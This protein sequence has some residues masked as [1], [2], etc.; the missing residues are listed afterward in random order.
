MKPY[1]LPK[2]LINDKLKS[3]TSN[4]NKEAVQMKPRRVFKEPL[5][6]NLKPLTLFFKRRNTMKTKIFFASLLIG[7][8]FLTSLSYPADE[9]RNV[10]WQGRF[11]DPGTQLVL[12]GNYNITYSIYQAASGGTALWSETQNTF[13]DSGIANVFLGSV[14]PIPD[15]V[16]NG[17]MMY[18]GVRVGSDPEM[19]PRSEIVCTPYARYAFAGGGW[20]DSGNVVTLATGTDK[21]GIGT[22]NPI[23]KLHVEGDAYISGVLRVGSPVFSG[24]TN[25]GFEAIGVF[26]KSCP[27]NVEPSASLEIVKDPV[28]NPDFLMF[29][30]TETADGDMLIVRN[31]GNVGIGTKTPQEKL[32]VNGGVKIGTTTNTNAGTIRWYNG[33]FQGY[34]GTVWVN[35]DE[36][37][38]TDNDWCGIGS[39]SL[40]PCT[41]TDKVGIGT[42]SPADMLHVKKDQGG[43]ITYAIVD[44]GSGGSNT[45]AGIRFRN[46]NGDAGAIY[47]LS[48]YNGNALVIEN[49]QVNSPIK[50]IA[51]GEMLTLQPT[52][53]PR[54]AIFE[55]DATV[56]IGTT[57]V[58]RL[59][60]EGAVAVGASY[61]GTNTAPTNGMIVQGNV[62]I[63]TTN[64]QSTLHVI[65]SV[66]G[67]TTGAVHINN[68]Y[69]DA[70]ALG[71]FASA[72][73]TGIRGYATNPDGGGILGYNAQMT[74]GTGIGSGVGGWANSLQGK[75]VF[76]N[77]FN[78]DG[79]AFYAWDGKNYFKGKVGIGTEFPNTKVDIDGDIA[80]RAGS[81]IATNGVTNHNIAIGARSFVRITGPNAPFTITGIAGGTDGKMVILYNATDQNMTIARESASSTAVNRILTMTTG[82]ET[83]LGT[84]NVTLIYD[85]TGPNPRWIVTAIKP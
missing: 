76:A 27:G 61:A 70:N 63:G 43:A 55:G 59:D 72:K 66:Y 38:G 39:G 21:V 5:T 49:Q 60:V 17:F 16:F 12:H 9:V 83:T 6:F 79:F 85:A 18:L 71:L 3:I 80:L 11:I 32:D 77:N 4:Q 62:G 1:E 64:P 54:K 28:Y 40:Y 22:K 7:V 81:F 19:V 75:A 67:D 29:S 45:G 42:A 30:S 78:P 53:A 34:N 74:T 84:G 31:N 48:G 82:D 24:T 15:S 25:A 26:H 47:S 52:G 65:G 2:K 36:V 13:I 68:T 10:M 33:H 20:K 35:L 8:L 37:G 46:N 69:T 23:A 73:T 41:L 14:T 57:P 58:N 44:N 51:N 56:G 50:F